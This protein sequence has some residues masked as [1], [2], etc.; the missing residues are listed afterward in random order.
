[1]EEET[2]QSGL[3]EQ[4]WTRWGSHRVCCIFKASVYS[5]RARPGHFTEKKKKKKRTN[6]LFIFLI[7]GIGDRG[8]RGLKLHKV[9][10]MIRTVV[11]LYWG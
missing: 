1:M 5:R 6:S 2:F 3:K 8:M 11:K 9:F 4:I 7:V 10:I